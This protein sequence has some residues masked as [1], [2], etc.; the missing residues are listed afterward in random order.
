MLTNLT[1]ITFESILQ[2]VHEAKDNGYRFVTMT[3]VDN[4]DGT[5][6]LYYHFDYNYELK[7]LKVTMPLGQEIPSISKI[8]FAAVLVENEIQELFGLRF[9]GKVIDYG[10]H[11]I[12]SDEELSNPMLTNQIII[13]QKESK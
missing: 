10:G 3:S 7:N 4:K 5:M 9:D 6:D 2:Q 11:F 1:E 13:E 8:Y 12:L